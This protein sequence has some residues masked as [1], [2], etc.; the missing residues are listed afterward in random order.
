MDSL[1][2][3]EIGYVKFFLHKK[4]HFYFEIQVEVMDHFF[5][6]LEEEKPKYPSMIFSDFVEQTYA[7]YA[8]DLE[9][10]K[11][12]LKK[13]LRTKYNWIFVQQFF[14]PLTNLHLLLVILGVVALYYLQIFI[15][16]YFGSLAFYVFTG[17][18]LLIML[19]KYSPPSDFLI[20]NFLTS[21]IAGN[22][23]IIVWIYSFCV[24]SFIRHANMNTSIIVDE[25]NISFLI[26]SIAIVVKAMIINAMIKTDW[27]GVKEAKKME[28][29]SEALNA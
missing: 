22:Y 5:S 14:K 29:A 20:G 1:T 6:V 18:P 11:V 2:N 12:S 17:I 13:K 27:I 26:I 28:P 15:S 21:K 4:K 3:E 24:F 8:A 23:G 10:I 19:F 9:S 16:D 25:L 7:K